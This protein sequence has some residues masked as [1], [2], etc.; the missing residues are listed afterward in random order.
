MV[1]GSDRVGSLELPKHVGASESG[2]NL[3]NIDAMAVVENLVLRFLLFVPDDYW[4]GGCGAD[5]IASRIQ[6]V[7]VAMVELTAVGLDIAQ[8][9]RLRE[10]VG[11][12]GLAAVKENWYEGGEREAKLDLREV[13]EDG[14]FEMGMV[15]AVVCGLEYL[16]F[17]RF[18]RGPRFVRR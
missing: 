14:R 10:W 15:G 6:K 11:G 7:V 16:L 5:P 13:G 1:R 8:E 18:V 12:V 4:A 2:T 3:G 9:D 17:G